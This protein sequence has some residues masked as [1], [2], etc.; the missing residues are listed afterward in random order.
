MRGSFGGA[1]GARP[2]SDEF[3]R[4]W[5]E[6]THRQLCV[7]EALSRGFSRKSGRSRGCHGR[8]VAVLVYRWVDPSLPVHWGVSFPP[9]VGSLGGGRGPVASVWCVRCMPTENMGSS[10]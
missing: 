6:R 9:I 4:E 5:E 7:C 8:T 10:V 1:A 3:I 2:D